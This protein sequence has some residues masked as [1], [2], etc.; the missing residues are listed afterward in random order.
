[1]D[2]SQPRVIYTAIYFDSGLN[3]FRQQRQLDRVINPQATGPI[4]VLTPGTVRQRRRCPQQRCSPVEAIERADRTSKTSLQRCA[5]VA[6]LLYDLG[7]DWFGESAQR[8]K[9]LVAVLP[10]IGY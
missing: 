2:C 8:L 4:I 1:M 10:Y 9:D 6:S 5:R 3:H 7:Y